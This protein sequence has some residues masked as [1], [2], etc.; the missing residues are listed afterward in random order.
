M[1]PP[2]FPRTYHWPTS[3]GVQSDDKIHS[4]PEWFLNR[5]ISISEKLDGGCTILSQG[6]PWSRASG[7]PATEGWFSAVRKHHAWKTSSLPESVA[8]YGED[9][10]AHHAI[11]YTIEEHAT[12]RTFHVLK[13]DVFESVDD[14]VTFSQAL[15]IPVVHEMFRGVFTK[16]LDLTAWLE[17]NIASPDS[18][19]STREGF[20]IRPTGSIPFSQY[21]DQVCKYVRKNHVQSNTHW[22]YNW[23][24]NNIQYTS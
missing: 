20:V 12:F 9:I 4:S 16:S 21:S 18:L 14:M 10:Y 17:E 6:V 1:T 11:D 23:H 5:E 2:K 8:L 19:G 24:T 3:P 22:R 13:G 15:D 7:S